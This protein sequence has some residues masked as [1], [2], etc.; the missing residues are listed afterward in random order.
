LFVSYKSFQTDAG[1]LAAMTQLERDGLL[2]IHGVPT[3]ETSNE[4]CEL[5]RVA[6]AFGEI[7]NTFYGPLWDVKNTRDSRNLAYTNLDLN[8]HTDL[9]LVSFHLRR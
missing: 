2:F 4:S 7:R 5:R 6:E 9:A 1:R 8:L 3:V